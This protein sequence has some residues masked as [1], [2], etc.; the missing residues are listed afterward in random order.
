MACFARGFRHLANKTLRI[1]AMSNA[2]GPD[3]EIIIAPGH[4]RTCCPVLQ[5]S[6]G[7]LMNKNTGLFVGSAVAPM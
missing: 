5:R 3:V 6:D 7:A 1:A 4:S 2:A